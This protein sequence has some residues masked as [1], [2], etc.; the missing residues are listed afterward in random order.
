LRVNV[1]SPV[2][3]Q[4]NGAPGPAEHGAVKRRAT[5]AVLTVNHP[6]LGIEQGP[7]PP[8]PAA[9]GGGVNRMVGASIRTIGC[10]HG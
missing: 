6:G 3:Q 5:E 7:N 9:F 10:G 4:R 1:G 2:Q 8:E